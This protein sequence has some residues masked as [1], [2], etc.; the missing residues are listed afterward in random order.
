M[1]PTVDGLASWDITVDLK[2]SNLQQWTM[3][4]YSIKVNEL[5]YFNWIKL[6]MIWNESLCCSFPA[7]TALVL[8][9]LHRASFWNL[10]VDRIGFVHER[11]DPGGLRAGDGSDGL[12]EQFDA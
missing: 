5:I 9:A 1:Y 6:F 10:A 3:K 8:R 11:G 7:T 12:V 2:E 4:N